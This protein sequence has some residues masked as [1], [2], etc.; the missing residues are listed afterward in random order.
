MCDAA[1]VFASTWQTRAV[2]VLI[3]CLLDV[4]FGDPKRGHPVALFGR[5]AA[6]LEQITYRDGRVAGAVHVGLLTIDYYAASH[7]TLTTRIVDPIRVLLIGGHSYLEAWSREAEGVRLFRFD[8]IVDAAELGEPAVPPESARQAP[9]DTSL[10]D[11]DLSLPSATLRVAPSASW[12]LEYY[13][14]RELRQLPDGSCEVAMTY[15]SED[16]MTRLLLGF[17]S[18]VRVLAPES[19]AQR[20]RDA[21]TAA[22]DAYQAAAPP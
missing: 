3:G 8:R 7:D 11:G 13:P 4:V 19:L 21:A 5:A 10:F 6:K 14:I 12:M 15:A 18:D 9:P 17:G 22:L 16:W 1:G 20:V 2:G